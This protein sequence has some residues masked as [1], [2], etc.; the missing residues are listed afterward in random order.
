MRPPSVIPVKRPL[1]DTAYGGS[2]LRD[3]ET[4]N[5]KGHRQSTTTPTNRLTVKSSSTQH[6]WIQD[7]VSVSFGLGS[8]MSVLIIQGLNTG[9][10][11]Y[12]PSLPPVAPIMQLSTGADP[13]KPP[14]HR[15]SHHAQTSFMPSAEVNFTTRSLGSAK[16]I[17][18]VDKKF[19]AC[20]LETGAKG[21]TL[22]LIDQHAAD[23][24]VAIEEILQDLCEGFVNDTI[25]QTEV[26][27]PVVFLTQ[28]EANQLSQPGAQ[29][30]IA[31]WGILL[32]LPE[33]TDGA[34]YIQVPVN[35]VP[36]VLAS[37]LARKEA[38]EITRLVRLYLEQLSEDLP[39]IL[40]AVGRFDGAQGEAQGDWQKVQRWMP[41]EM[42]ELANSKACR[43][44]SMA[45]SDL[46]AWLM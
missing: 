3:M 19:I 7:I 23:E 5:A 25:R 12:S 45:V 40:T 27:G 36:T 43:S 15:C 31:R 38:S 10:M 4:P 1:G 13:L 30:V 44:K 22:V 46:C 6:Q 35:A 37:R 33:Y 16:I 29:D 28:A 8:A 11:P 17:G 26:S 34:D 20:F 24:R 32:D 42:L 9:V 39:E 14:R 21:R 18:Q 41:L 2:P